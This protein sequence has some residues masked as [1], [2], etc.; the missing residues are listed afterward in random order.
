MR[1]WLSNVFRLGLKEFASLRRDVVMLG[2][3]VFVF[4]VT[5]Y[6]MATGFKTDVS[7][8]GIA[9]VDA[10]RSVLSGRI[11]D[12][13]QPP[14]FRPPLL[15]DRSEADDLLDKGTVTFVL[16]I[17]PA[18]EAD[19]LAGRGPAI[20]VNVDA[21]A[22]SLAGVGT[23]YLQQ[24]VTAE[25]QR[26][27]H[28]H[29][30][31]SALPVVPVVR[32]L[33]NENL[34]AIRFNAT[35][36]VMTNVT[37]LGLILVGAAIMRER[38]HGTIEHLLVMPVRA[39]EIAAAKIWANSLVVLVAS[40]LSLHL[41]VRLVL[42]VPVVGSIE[43]FLVGT[44]VYLFAVTSLGILLATIANSMPQFSLLA[45]PVF[46]VM[47]LLSGTFTPFESMP[48]ALQAIMRGVPFTH[49][50]MF[51]QSV[52]ARGAGLADVWPH[53]AFM[54]ASGAAFLTAALLR[55]RSTLS[56]PS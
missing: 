20:Q 8:A 5:P 14:Y 23:A 38:E 9:V 41:V 31:G 10:D 1:W 27:L 4:T 43:L 17:P 42:G 29:D 36:D 39:S 45:I 37:L 16:E 13:I 15:I 18:L 26:F 11:V 3:I 19:L 28:A 22:V 21:T 25:A 6:T 24:I 34:E 56:R 30:P 40:G 55:F 7:N 46:V 35:M 51:T 50:V 53:L 48:P 44:A 49:F 52:L 12:A 54:T 33:F 47:L 32:A 2:L